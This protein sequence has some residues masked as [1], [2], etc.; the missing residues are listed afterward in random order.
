M[1]DPVLRLEP[2]R[3]TVEPG[4]QVSLQVTVHNPGTIVE[5]YTLDVVG[6]QPITWAE[7]VPPAVSVYPQQQETATVLFRPPGGAATPGGLVPFGVRATSSVDPTARAVAEGELTVGQVSGL[8]AKLIPVTSSGRWSGRHTVQISNWGNA[9]ATLRL[10]ASDPDQALGF[11]VRPNVVEVPLGGTATAGLKVRTRKP[12][13][14]GTPARL[15]FQV[16]GE[17]EKPGPVTGSVLP[18]ADPSRPVA[19]GAFNQKPILSRMTVTAG[20][21]G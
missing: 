2:D 16:V 4:G 9:P 12:V 17:P 14:R 15:P 11:L 3:L 5:S 1:T 8:Q 6:E 13:L 18:Y 21:L 7:V 10:V 19:D 20:V